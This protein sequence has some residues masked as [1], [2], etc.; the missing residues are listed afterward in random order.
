VQRADDS[1]FNQIMVD[2]PDIQGLPEAKSVDED[3]SEQ[4]RTSA[5]STSADRQRRLEA[6]DGV[7]ERIA[8]ITYAYTRNPDVV[9]EVLLRANGVCERCNCPAPFRRKSDHQP[10][11]E[12]HHTIPLAAGGLD[13]VANAEALCPNC[14]REAHYGGA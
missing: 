2:V 9:A 12:V 8:V 5:G 11:L 3:F 4:V 6:S 14:H 13:V 1:F 10:Y 7:V